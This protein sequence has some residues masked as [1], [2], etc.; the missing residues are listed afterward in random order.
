MDHG[1][2][3][4]TTHRDSNHA[5]YCARANSLVSSSFGFTGCNKRTRVACHPLK[6]TFY[7]RLRKKIYWIYRDP[8]IST[9]RSIAF[10]EQS[11]YLLSDNA[12][13]L[14]SL[15]SIYLEK[16]NLFRLV[17]FDIALLFSKKKK[18]RKIQLNKILKNLLFN[19]NSICYNSR[20]LSLWKNVRSH[21]LKI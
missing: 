17:Q 21:P 3:S 20:V 7:L 6:K 10:F 2:S 12:T 13:Q 1:V 16:R 9:Y 19:D 11:Y 14:G 18:K 15:L 8:S 5:P 4:Q